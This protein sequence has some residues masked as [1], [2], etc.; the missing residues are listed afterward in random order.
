M[1]M[2]GVLAG[3]LL[4]QKRVVIF[5]AQH[6]A[7]IM[8]VIA[9]TVE[10]CHNADGIYRLNTAGE[11][12]VKEV[13]AN[14]EL[15]LLHLSCPDTLKC[16]HDGYLLHCHIVKFDHGSHRSPHDKVSVNK[17]MGRN[18]K[19]QTIYRTA[20][21]QEQL[22]G[23]NFLVIPQGIGE[24]VDKLRRERRLLSG[25]VDAFR[26]GKRIVRIVHMAQQIPVA[27]CNDDGIPHQAGEDSAQILQSAGGQ[28]RRHDLPVYR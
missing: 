10:L 7:A 26:Q 4:P 17:I 12:I 1:G 25:N 15:G 27:V 16:R 11:E 13:L 22:P 20:V 3:Q 9:Q 28:C 19:D 23:D 14:A 6:K 18:G 2:E 5:K 8:V 24:A 21:S